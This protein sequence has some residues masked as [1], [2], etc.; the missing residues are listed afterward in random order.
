MNNKQLGT[1]WEQ[2]FCKLLASEGYWVHFIS[3]APDGSQPFDVIAAKAGEAYAYD[4]KTCSADVFSID[5]L[6]DNQVMAFEKWIRC[7]NSDPRVAVMHN[8]RVYLI[9]YAQLKSFGRIRLNDDG[10]TSVRRSKL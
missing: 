8:N 1:Q 10:S 9:S 7:G 5:R 2:E 3:P 4:C 6:E